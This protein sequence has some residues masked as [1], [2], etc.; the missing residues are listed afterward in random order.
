MYLLG[1]SPRWEG[2]LRKVF[3]EIYPLERCGKLYISS[4]AFILEYIFLARTVIDC[5]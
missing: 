1:R 2:I 4:D 5:S 3:F